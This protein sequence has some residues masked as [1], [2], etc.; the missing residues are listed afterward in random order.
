MVAANREVVTNEEIKDRLDEA[1][2]V[3]MHGKKRA[4]EGCVASEAL[5]VFRKALD[6]IVRLKDAIERP[7]I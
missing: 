1:I 5:I 6:D 4:E 7:S 2:A 3:L